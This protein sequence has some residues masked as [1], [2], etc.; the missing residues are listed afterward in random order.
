[1][2]SDPLGFSMPRL[3]LL[4]FTAPLLLGCVSS[5]RHA[6]NDVAARDVAPAP[7]GYAGDSLEQ[8]LSWSEPDNGLVARIEYLIP[9]TAHDGGA[10]YLRLKNVEDEPVTVPAGEIGGM[11]FTRC[12]ELYYWDNDKWHPIYWP[13]H[14]WFRSVPDTI[15]LQPGQ[16]TLLGLTSGLPRRLMAYS[17]LKVVV[18]MPGTTLLKQLDPIRDED[19]D[20]LNDDPDDDRWVQGPRLRRFNVQTPAFP[21]R[22]TGAMDAQREGKYPG[23]DVW[24]FEVSDA[25]PGEILDALLGN[26]PLNPIQLQV[27]IGGNSKRLRLLPLYAQETRLAEFERLLD[28]Y[29]QSPYDPH[30]RLMF[31]AFAARDGSAKGRA[32]IHETIQT[33]RGERLRGA[34]A[35][36]GFLLEQE[37]P[38]AWAEQAAI[39]AI[40]DK[41]VID[42]QGEYERT[43]ADLAINDHGNI[44]YRLASRKCK[45]A[46]PALIKRIQTEG[47]EQATIS[48][49]GEIGDPRAIP[50]L[51][52]MLQEQLDQGWDPDYGKPT[53]LQAI[54]RIQAEQAVVPLIQ[55]I[56][57]PGVPETL[58]HIGDPRAIPALRT[59][60]DEGNLEAKIAL[61]R[62]G[63]PGMFEQLLEAKDNERYTGWARINAMFVLSESQDP[64]MLPVLVEWIEADESGVVATLAIRALA[65]YDTPEAVE[66]LIACFEVDFSQKAG[67]PPAYQTEHYTGHIAEALTRMTGQ[68]FGDNPDTWRTWWAKGGKQHYSD[69]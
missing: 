61:Y 7:P 55:H 54:G 6:V 68:T 37:G 65:K 25:V 51:I 12:F 1:M 60:A 36:V 43:V 18:R 49:L 28:Q 10:V 64:R 22:F 14:R 45:E 66:A 34:I 53:V 56:E 26:G 23:P 8:W 39:Q 17:H 69:R 11:D 24:P 30:Q 15:E 33:G 59:L 42:K 4:L 13:S 48:A 50:L 3:I 67:W 57:M 47:G 32:L 58:G 19:V 63:E 52:D 31:A 16:T 40:R 44:V 29:E 35:A 27:L 5:P 41:R 21:T 2:V 46:V 38:Q 20:G 9:P 62:L